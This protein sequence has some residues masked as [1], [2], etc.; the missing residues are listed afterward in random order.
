MCAPSVLIGALSC[1]SVWNSFAFVPARHDA[2][3]SVAS[4]EEATEAS[5]V[6]WSRL[7]SVREVGGIRRGAAAARLVASFRAFGGEDGEIAEDLHSVIG[8][9]LNPK[10]RPREDAAG[11]TIVVVGNGKS[12]CNA[13]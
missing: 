8:C 11:R 3:V 4:E 7:A 13:T 10:M 5:R 9:I 12:P 1:R 2:A 6:P